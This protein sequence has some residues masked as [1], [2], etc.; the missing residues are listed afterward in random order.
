MQ[1][2]KAAFGGEGPVA[3][4]PEGSQVG[5][6]AAGAH[7]AQGMAGVVHPLTIEGAVLLVDQSVNHAQDLALHG[8]ERLGGFG[9]DQVLVQRNHDLG[10]WQHKIGQR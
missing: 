9:F 2:P 8:G 10:Q 4:D 3:G 7:G 5:D 6:G 1:A